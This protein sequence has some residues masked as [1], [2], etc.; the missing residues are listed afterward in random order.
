DKLMA[1]RQNARQIVLP[2]PDLTPQRDK[3]SDALREVLA[4]V[5]ARTGNDFSSYKSST[6][7]R[8]I[9]RRLQVNEVT[10]IPSYLNFIRE[11]QE[12]VHA[13]LRDLLISV[14]HFFR[15]HEAFEH[16]ERDVIP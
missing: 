10:D 8:R 2:A 16:L 13:L 15:D 3:A 7:L 12:E 1:L 11:H 14:T 4:L 6:I 9:E 5:R